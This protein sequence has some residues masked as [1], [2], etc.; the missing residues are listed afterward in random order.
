MLIGAA[1]FLALFRYK[2]GVMPVIGASALAGLLLTFL[3]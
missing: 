2:V 1:A 3:R